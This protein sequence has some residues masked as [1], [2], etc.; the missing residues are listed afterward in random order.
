[1]R[2]DLLNRSLTV[3]RNTNLVRDEGQESAYRQDSV[4]QQIF[5]PMVEPLRMELLDFMD[6][7]I[8]HKEPAANG[9]AACQTIAI[10]ETVS[11]Q[12]MRLL[13]NGRVRK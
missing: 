7:V 11:R 8:S 4:T 6:C 2:A 12:A 13:T 9:F 5:V 1:M 10:A 3:Q